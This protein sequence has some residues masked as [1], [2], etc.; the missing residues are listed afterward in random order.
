MQTMKKLHA[1]GLAAGLLI[2]ASAVFANTTFN[3]QSGN[4]ALPTAKVTPYGALIVAADYQ[5][6]KDIINTEKDSGAIFVRCGI[7]ENAELGV[8]YRIFQYASPA[9][10]G[11]NGNTINVSGKYMTPIKLLG[12]DW[13]ASADYGVTHKFDAFPDDIKTTQIAWVGDQKFKIGDYTMVTGTVGVNWTEQDMGAAG[14]PHAVRY[15]AGA[16]VPLIENITVL[17]DYQTAS[18]NLDMKSLYGLAVCYQAKSDLMIK[19]GVSNAYPSGEVNGAGQ[20]KPF[21]AV[22]MK[23]NSK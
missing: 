19:G 8:G 5:N 10:S 3:G 12:F 16:A 4:V 20:A 13:S 9:A 11:D 6:T 14:K 2:A 22:S 7:A 21:I 17:G 18:S 23:F 15:F 1:L